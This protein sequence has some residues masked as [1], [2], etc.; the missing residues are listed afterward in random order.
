MKKIE[1][2]K[3]MKKNCL[4]QKGKKLKSKYGKNDSSRDLNYFILNNKFYYSVV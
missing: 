1:K 4:N 2:K 3:N